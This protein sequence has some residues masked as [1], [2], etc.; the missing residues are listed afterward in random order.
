MPKKTHRRIGKRPKL[1][2]EFPTTIRGL[3]HET[4]MSQMRIVLNAS[5]V[6]AIMDLMNEAELD[7]SLHEVL[8]DEN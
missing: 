8:A 2:C 4:G 5:E 7:L 6:D 3:R 1:F